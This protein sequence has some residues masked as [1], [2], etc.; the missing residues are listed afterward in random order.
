M[1]NSQEQAPTK[2]LAQQLQTASPNM[3]MQNS[4]MPNQQQY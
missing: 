3:A 1:T 4:M 2:S